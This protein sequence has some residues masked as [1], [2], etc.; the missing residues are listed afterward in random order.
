MLLS[1]TLTESEARD[2][3][4]WTYPSPL[5]LYDVEPANPDLFL[6][7][8]R[9]GDGYYPV[10]DDAATLIA[11]AVFGEEAR[12]AGQEPAVDVLNVEPGV[13]P[14]LTSRDKAV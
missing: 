14:G 12:V 1:R 8:S 5:D 6:R 3:A 4:A 10:V 7:R 11:F 13:R 2:V 9:A